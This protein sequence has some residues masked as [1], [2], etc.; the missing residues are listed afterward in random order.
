[1]LGSGGW[2]VIGCTLNAI[3]SDSNFFDD[4]TELIASAKLHSPTTAPEDP[5]SSQTIGWSDFFEIEEDLKKI[6]ATKN[7][8]ISASARE[9]ECW[10]V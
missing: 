10:R 9:N 4:S 2:D 3:G 5:F 6:P 8:E 7:A 1:M